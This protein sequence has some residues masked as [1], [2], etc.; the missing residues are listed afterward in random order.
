LAR[1]YKP[2]GGVYSLTIPCAVCVGADADWF[3]EDW[4]AAVA[5][6]A[7]SISE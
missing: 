6:L 5:P 4:S 1:A 7:W 2:G 3:E